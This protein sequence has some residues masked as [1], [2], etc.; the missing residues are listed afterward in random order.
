VF[1]EKKGHLKNCSKHPT[2]KRNQDQEQALRNYLQ[3]TL[4]KTKTRLNWPTHGPMLS[5][6]NTPLFLAMLFPTLFPYGLRDA[7][8]EINEWM[9]P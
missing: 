1:Q 7:Q 6:Y 5:D 8:I 9:Y 2:I 3:E 4:K